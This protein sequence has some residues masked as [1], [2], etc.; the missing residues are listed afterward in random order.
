MT[1]VEPRPRFFEGQYLDAAD[2]DAAVDYARAQLSRVLLGAHRWGIALGLELHEVAGPNNMV[3]VVVQP[4]YAWDGFG[5]PIVVAEPYKLPASLFA[6]F[7]PDIVSGGP[8]PPAVVVDVW[9]AYDETMTQAPR[10]GFET[11]DTVDPYARVREGFRIEVGPRTQVPARR[12]PISVAGRIVDAAQALRAFDATAPQL[13]D[14]SIPYQL[15]PATGERALWL[16]PLGVVSWQPGSPGTFGQRTPA[17]LA[18]SERAREYTGVVVRSVEATNGHV[19]VHDRARPYSQFATGELLWVEGDVRI[20]GDARLYGGMVEFADS[21]AESPIEPFRALRSDDLSG[22]KLQL[23]IGSD[24]A[25][26][27]RLAVGPRTAQNPDVYAEHL[28]VTDAGKV[29][30]GTSQPKALLHLKEDGLEIGTSAT[31]ED[32]FYLQSNTDGPRALRIYNKDVGAGSH[33]TSFTATGRVGIGT[34]DPTNVLHVGGSLGIRQNALYVSGDPAWS[35]LTFNAH[36]NP[37]N[38]AWVFPDPSK[39]AVTIE[40][41]AWGGSPRFEV[42]STALGNNQAWMSRLWVS[43]HTGDVGMAANGG[44][45]GIGT[46]APGAK[47]DV[48]GDVRVTGDVALGPSALRPVAGTSGLR[49]VWGRVGGNGTVDGGEGFSVVRQG[50]GRYRITFDTPF[51]IEPTVIVTNIFGSVAVDA[52]TSVLPAENALV[53]QILPA[54]AVIA[55]GNSTGGRADKSFCFIAVGP[56]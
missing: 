35:S 25:G 32:N 14:A 7:D 1:D 2:L 44:S 4:G 3:D 23:A 15:L 52:G 47:L 49:I 40:M 36:H 56:R 17:D 53:D 30:I 16:I 12:D 55:T 24:S 48:R 39:P 10:P 51:P 18:R 27:N 9:L 31:P 46:Y 28:V 29:G 22:K 45:V 54:S 33:I 41:D 8:P 43:G 42:Y 34:T 13:P 6:P 37:A 19:R 21:L 5:R 38:N 20:D 11:C 26:A 50:P